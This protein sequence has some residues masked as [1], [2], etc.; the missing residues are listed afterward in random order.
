MVECCFERRASCV[1]EDVS[2]TGETRRQV[3]LCDFDQNTE[4]GSDQYGS[5]CRTLQVERPG[6]VDGKKK[7]YGDETS[8]IQ[9]TV[10]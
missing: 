2:Y 9:L 3:S 5:Q 8:N 1:R 10:L 7:P 4:N 6:E